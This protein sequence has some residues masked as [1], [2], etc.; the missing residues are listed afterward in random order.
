M[1]SPGNVT[2]AVRSK[3]D[4]CRRFA[5]QTHVE[6]TQSGGC[7]CFLDLQASVQVH[8]IGSHNPDHTKSSVELPSVTI[9]CAVNGK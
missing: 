3:S 9:T 1:L 4:P 6:A 8:L 5:N 7:R 2:L